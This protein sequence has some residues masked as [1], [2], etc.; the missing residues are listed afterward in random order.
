MDLWNWPIR[1]L[2]DGH[3]EPATALWNWPIRE[4][5]DGHFRASCGPVELAN[6]RAR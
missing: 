4:L 2:G 5:G 1:E 6:Q 3:L